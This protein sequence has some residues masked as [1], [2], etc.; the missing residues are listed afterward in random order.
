MKRIKSQ[1]VNI[2][3]IFD[4]INMLLI[5]TFYDIKLILDVIMFVYKF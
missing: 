5:E 3:L 2:F 4:Q 1:N